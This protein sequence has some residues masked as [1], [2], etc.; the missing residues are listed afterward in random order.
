MFSDRDRSLLRRP[1]PTFPCVTMPQP[2]PESSSKPAV[3]VPVTEISD[4]LRLDSA[5]QAL[6]EPWRETVEPRSCSFLQ[7]SKFHADATL[8]RNCG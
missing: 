5:R 1:S 6:D 8:S 2:R 3:V 7:L 4:S